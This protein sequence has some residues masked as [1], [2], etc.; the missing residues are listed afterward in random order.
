MAGG[1]LAPAVA[2]AGRAPS[3]HLNTI[4]N[5]SMSTAWVWLVGSRRMPEYKDRRV[6]LNGTT[7]ITLGGMTTI[8]LK[9]PRPLLR[10]LEAE[11]ASQGVSKSEVVRTCLEEGLR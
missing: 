8:S 10:D 2:T 11:A 4:G 9:M 1:A 7:G 3:I 6:L 5:G